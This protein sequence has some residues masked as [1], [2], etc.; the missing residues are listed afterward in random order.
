MSLGFPAT[1]GRYTLLEK[2]ASG[3]MGTVYLAKTESALGF[4]KLFAI[5]TILPEFAEDE[6]FRAML[7]DEARIL[8]GIDHP[9]VAHIFELATDRG[10]LFLVM[11]YVEGAPFGWCL[12]RAR[13]ICEGKRLPLGVSLR[14]A[15][16]ACAGLHA[17][18][19]LR[20]ATG[21]LVGVVH[22]DVSPQ[23]ILV[24]R[25]GMAKMIDFGVAKARHRVGGDTVFEGLKGKVRYMAPEYARGEPI[26]RRA[27]VFAMGCILYRALTNTYPY[28]AATDAATLTKLVS[29]VAPPPPHATPEPVRRVVMA[30]LAPRA[31]DRQPT[32]QVLRTELEDAMRRSG[33]VTTVEDV[34]AFLVDTLG[35]R[36][37][38]GH[39]TMRGTSVGRIRAGLRAQLA[40][41]A[42]AEDDASPSTPPVPDENLAET[43]SSP[44]VRDT[45]PA[46]LVSDSTC[47]VGPSEAST[48]D[49][50]A[51]RRRSWTAAIVLAAGAALV[52]LAGSFVARAPAPPAASMTSTTTSVPP[53]ADDLV[54]A[55]ALES[56]SVELRIHAPDASSNAPPRAV[57]ANAPQRTEAVV[58]ADAPKPQPA[59]PSAPP[60]PTIRAAAPRPAAPARTQAPRR[61]KE[62]EKEKESSIDSLLD[63]R[64]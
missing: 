13:S 15:A 23:N 37:R 2:L 1:L 10:L 35:F 40:P 41:A 51:P 27:D 45:T 14:I 9:N 16:D 38:E 42:G 53:P 19:E 20:D 61:E 11:E 3:G 30:A 52:A 24:A 54:G 8:S 62:K 17:A 25:G 12:S 21:S 5:K 47:S 48:F 57:E 43:L 55:T 56:P 36:A 50:E 7:V 4:E 44:A 33:L 34:S 58:A 28:D 49:L 60:P 63:G 18:H 29:G 22:R 6:L 64:H 32:A 46:A 59:A 26:D 31:E 39:G